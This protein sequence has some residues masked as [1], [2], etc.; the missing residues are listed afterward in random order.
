MSAHSFL[1]FMHMIEQPQ[2]GTVPV[3]VHRPPVPLTFIACIKQFTPS[4]PCYNSTLTA[5]AARNINAPQT[6]PGTHESATSSSST[7]RL[8]A[9]VWCRTSRYSRPFD[10]ITQ[11]VSIL[12]H[13]RLIQ[14]C[15]MIVVLTTYFITYRMSKYRSMSNYAGM[16]MNCVT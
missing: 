6:M 7:T 10:T 3:S 8:P 9:S 2:P 14:A 12:H 5:D 4:E 11:C 16:R 15:D 1:T 13:Y